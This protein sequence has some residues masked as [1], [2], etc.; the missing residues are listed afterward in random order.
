MALKVVLVFQVE[1]L[2]VLFVKP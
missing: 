1:P 2:H